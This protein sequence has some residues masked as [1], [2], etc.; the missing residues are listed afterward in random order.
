MKVITW[1]VTLIFW[2]GFIS[3]KDNTIALDKIVSLSGDRFP[4]YKHKLDMLLERDIFV[5]YA[6]N[7]YGLNPEYKDIK[8]VFKVLIGLAVL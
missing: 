6:D 3:R 5:E 1:P 4:I 8:D 7:K 2:I